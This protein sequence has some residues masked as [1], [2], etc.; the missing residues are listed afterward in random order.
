MFVALRR[1]NSE[2]GQICG[3]LFSMR[4]FFIGSYW[5]RKEKYLEIILLRLA[6]IL[7]VVSTIMR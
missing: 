2:T 4:C 5:S 6:K 3:R 7:Y 1:A